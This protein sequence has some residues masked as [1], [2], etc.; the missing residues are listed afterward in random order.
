MPSYMLSVKLATKRLICAAPLTRLSESSTSWRGCKKTSSTLPSST[1]SWKSSR[2]KFS[3][4][5]RKQGRLTNLGQFLS[6][7]DSLTGRSPSGRTSNDRRR[8]TT[9]TQTRLED[10]NAIRPMDHQRS[11]TRTSIDGS[12][13]F[14]RDQFRHSALEPP[15][16]R[17]GHNHHNDHNRRSHRQA[18]IRRTGKFRIVCFAVNATIVIFAKRL[19]RWKH[20]KIEWPKVG[21]VSLVSKGITWP[22][23]AKTSDHAS[24]AKRVGITARFARSSL[25]HRDQSV[26]Q[27]PTSQQMHNQIERLGSLRVTQMTRVPRHHELSHKSPAQI[28]SI[29]QVMK[30]ALEKRHQFFSPRGLASTTQRIRNARC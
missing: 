30:R 8:T 2:E 26:S 13:R 3:S 12:R 1:P 4:T 18:S 11:R 22:L 19:L 9:T 28:S 25:D 6:Y 15:L 7:D 17:A 14:Q 5:W 29:R 16:H 10:H 27:V 20:A 24:T 23:N 21:D